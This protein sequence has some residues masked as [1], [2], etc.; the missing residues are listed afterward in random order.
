MQCGFLKREQLVPMLKHSIPMLVV[1]Y[2]FNRC[3]PINIPGYYA[4]I[5]VGILLPLIVI[6]GGIACRKSGY[7]AI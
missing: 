5:L 3:L 7:L 1:V 6:G 4:N 2:V